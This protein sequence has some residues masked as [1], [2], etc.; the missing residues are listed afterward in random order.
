MGSP[1]A[2]LTRVSLAVAPFSPGMKLWTR[3]PW[4]FYR[5]GLN[6]KRSMGQDSERMGA[7]RERWGSVIS[8]WGSLSTQCGQQLSLPWQGFSQAEVT[9]TFRSTSREASQLGSR[10]MRAPFPAFL[11]RKAS[12]CGWNRGALGLFPQRLSFPEEAGVY[13]SSVFS[14]EVWPGLPGL[15]TGG[16]TCWVQLSPP[17]GHLPPPRLGNGQ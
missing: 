8:P 17:R 13:T 14:L 4:K 1:S 15:L 16:Q 6:N 12:S 11:E 9:C 2:C 7:V 3:P 10:P 5:A